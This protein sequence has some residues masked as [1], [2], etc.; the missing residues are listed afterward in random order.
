[1]WTFILVVVI[2]YSLKI[3][4]RLFFGG[5]VLIA[6]ATDNLTASADGEDT[7]VFHAVCRLVRLIVTIPMFIWGLILLF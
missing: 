6:A 1:M 7:M 2:L 3:L 4:G 5:G